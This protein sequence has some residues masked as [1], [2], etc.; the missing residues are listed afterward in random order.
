MLTQ[1]V[2]DKF[3][4][5][6]THDHPS[7]EHFYTFYHFGK[8]CDRI[9]EMGVDYA[10]STWAWVASDP[11]YLRCVDIRRQP[12]PQGQ[13]DEI[14]EEVKKMGMDYQFVIADTGH[15]ILKEIEQ[16]FRKVSYPPD[17]V[18]LP[19]YNIEGEVDLLYIDTYH[20]YTHL[21]AELDIHAGKVKKYLLFHDTEY[22][23]ERH[24]Y[25]GDK[26]LNYA[27]REFLKDNPHW[28]YLHKVDYGNGLTVLGNTKNVKDK[29]DLDPN[30]RYPEV[31]L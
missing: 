17:Q 4:Y 10:V 20:S 23:G 26:G 7:M 3:N 9:V 8:K 24:D 22:F 6:S 1:K 31:K 16:K 25:D 28:K 13:H 27:I 12:P 30:F 2:K 5:Y 21:K 15:G 14:E 19:P 29:P 18:N 11:K